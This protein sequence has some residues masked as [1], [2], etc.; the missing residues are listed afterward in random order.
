M[1]LVLKTSGR[2]TWGFESLTILQGSG[3]GMATDRSANPRSPEGVEVRVLPAP[4]EENSLRARCGLTSDGGGTATG[5]R[6]LASPP[7][8]AQQE[9]L[10]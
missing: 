10:V 9:G 8:R 1:A 2:K 3:A 7:H 4:P 5:G 6:G